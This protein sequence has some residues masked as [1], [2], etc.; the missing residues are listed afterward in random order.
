MA[1]KKHSTSFSSIIKSGIS[2]AFVN[3]ILCNL[4]AWV[5]STMS[6]YSM[7]AFISVANITAAAIAITL[8][9]SLIY[10]ITVNLFSSI[11]ILYFL[12]S[13][14][15]HFIMILF[16]MNY[17]N[18]D[19]IPLP[20]KLSFLFNAGIVISGFTNIVLLPWLTSARY[21]GTLQKEKEEADYKF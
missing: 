10:F 7:P 19:S 9:F 12:F 20:E 16:I 1:Y 2:A 13:I 8:S 18:E 15:C 17:T 11:R 4:F 3:V 21:T 6:G 14:I 5:Y